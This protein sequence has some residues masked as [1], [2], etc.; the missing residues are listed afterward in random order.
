MNLIMPLCYFDGFHKD[1]FIT[2]DEFSQVE[3]NILHYVVLNTF[4]CI[5][6]FRPQKLWT[7]NKLSLFSNGLTEIRMEDLG[8]RPII[9]NKEKNMKI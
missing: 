1:G 8:M 9:K 3:I 2:K 7:R 4:F 5:Y 6:I